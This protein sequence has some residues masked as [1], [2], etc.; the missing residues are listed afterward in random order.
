MAKNIEIQINT[1]SNTYEV[2][3]PKTLG[4]LVD[5]NVSNADSAISANTLNSV[6]E[7]GKGGTGVTSYSSLANNLSNY[8]PNTDV[9]IVHYE[10]AGYSNTTQIQIPYISG[11]S[12]VG[13]IVGGTWIN[14]YETS[15]NNKLTFVCGFWKG[16]NSSTISAL[17]YDYS[18]KAILGGQFNNAGFRLRYTNVSTSYIETWN[19]SQINGEKYIL[20]LFYA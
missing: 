6:L 17:I 7:V 12:P 10:G 11:K 13:A 3:Y 20:V 2:L 16:E 9:R 1:G 18:T 5:G 4:S 19:G 14:T 8:I 15:G